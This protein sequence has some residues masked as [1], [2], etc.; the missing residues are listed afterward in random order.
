MTN[1]QIAAV[2]DEIAE[3]L[4]LED[5]NVFRIRS[6]ERVAEAIRGLGTPLAE[7]REAGE[8]ES[9]P[10]VGKA[11]A[12]KIEE[13]L[14]TGGLEFLEKLR[15][16]YPEGFLDMLRVPGLGPKRAS[17]I[18]RELGVGNVDE[19]RQAAEAGRIREL[20]GMGERSEAK[21]LEAIDTRAEGQE[22]ALLGEVLPLAEEVVGFLRGLADVIEADYAGS[23]R[24]G[25]ET[26]GD[27]DVLA[28]SDQPAA[29]CRAF[30]GSGLL[31]RVDLAGDTKVSGALPDGRQMD[32]RV[33]EP[34][35]YG[36]A[37]LYFT[38]S[39]QHN[40]RLRERGQRM[41]LTLNEYGLFEIDADG[42]PGERVAG[43]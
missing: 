33:V 12:A 9:I 38:G 6:Y 30:A 1:E 19:L 31:G 39:Q 35:S 11:I 40:I 4:Q 32:L 3:L 18:Y 25:R 2:F 23:V 22:R 43:E 27:L 37:L 42:E 10:G 21:L 15:S 8:L 41:E 28:T 17:M 7:M 16:H 14:D 36:A 20:P 13:L 26:V 5:E 24:R 29:V 34:P